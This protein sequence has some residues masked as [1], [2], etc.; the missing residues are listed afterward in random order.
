VK[1]VMDSAFAE[2]RDASSQPGSGRMIRRSGALGFR[3]V[4]ARAASRQ[5]SV[6]LGDFRRSIDIQPTNQ[7][8]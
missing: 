8:Q 6:N 2:D 1:T 5:L 4:L 3:L 7:A